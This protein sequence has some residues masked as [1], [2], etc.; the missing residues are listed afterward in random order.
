MVL[1][2]AGKTSLPTARASESTVL[3]PIPQHQES[4]GA[5][6]PSFQIVAMLPNQSALCKAEIGYS[7]GAALSPD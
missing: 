7:P 2:Q 1:Q 3:A 5:H 6:S 4:L